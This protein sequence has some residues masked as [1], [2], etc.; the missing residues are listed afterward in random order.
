[1]SFF[2]EYL[3]LPSRGRILVAATP[4]TAS[5]ANHAA[6]VQERE[7]L[8][9]GKL[10]HRKTTTLTKEGQIMNIHKAIQYPPKA[11]HKVRTAFNL[12]TLLNCSLLFHHC[13]RSNCQSE[14][15]STIVLYD[16]RVIIND[17]SIS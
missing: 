10:Y 13:T 7:P 6:T 11:T 9:K 12:A 8:W 1:M 17:S 16:S 3:L 14:K 15:R 4:V 5:H 2:P